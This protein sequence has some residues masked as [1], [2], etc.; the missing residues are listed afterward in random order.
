MFMNL[1][2]SLM[3]V[4]VVIVEGDENDYCDSFVS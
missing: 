1:R 2:I 3:V 4:L